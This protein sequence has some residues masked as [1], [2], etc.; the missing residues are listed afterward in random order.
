MSSLEEVRLTLGHTFS[1]GLCCDRPTHLPASSLKAFLSPCRVPV[2]ADIWNPFVESPTISTVTAKALLSLFTNPL[3]I[4][5][6]LLYNLS[7]LSPVLLKFSMLCSELTS[8]IFSKTRNSSAAHH[9]VSDVSATSC[10]L[11]MQLL[12]STNQCVTWA[13]SED[14]STMPASS[15]NFWLLPHSVACHI[16]CMCSACCP[17]D[18]SSGI[19]CV[20]LTW[21]KCWVYVRC[22]MAA[23][24]IQ[25]RA[26]C[27]TVTLS[28][29]DYTSLSVAAS[30]WVLK[31]QN[32]SAASQDESRGETQIPH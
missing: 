31:N 20:R 9:L 15:L 21:K 8:F 12:W 18:L 10:Q 27:A 13:S 6:S 7:R 16:W 3:R 23:G 29:W 24:Q 2:T 4:P 30:S 32:I 14:T 22:T 26:N 17:S 19:F 25:S 28:A 11:W 5:L 1:L